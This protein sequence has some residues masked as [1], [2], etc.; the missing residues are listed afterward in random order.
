VAR[1]VP[2]V[3]IALVSLAI[4]GCGEASKG[5]TVGATELVPSAT[6]KSDE[7]EFCASLRRQRSPSIKTVRP[8]SPGQEID[9]NAVAARARWYK[10]VRR[11]PF[12]SKL[13]ANRVYLKKFMSA[14]DA[15]EQMLYAVNDVK[16]GRIQEAHPELVE[17]GDQ[18]VDPDR[19]AG[20]VPHLYAKSMGAFALAGLDDCIDKFDWVI[21][22]AGV[23]ESR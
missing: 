14:M 9:P 12:R 21:A 15:R 16:E 10:Y 5:Q 22:Y 18:P 20:T 19:S 8:Y 17:E 1:S 7:N 2:W 3:L 11:D 4:S 23:S 13:T 6:L